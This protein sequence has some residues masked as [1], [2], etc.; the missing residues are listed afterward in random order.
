[1]ETE[2]RI[3]ISKNYKSV[4][5]EELF[6]AMKRSKNHKDLKREIVNLKR[7]FLDKEMIVNVEKPYEA[8]YESQRQFLEKNKI[9]HETKIED[10]EDLFSQDHKKLMKENMNLIRIINDLERE[11]KEIEEKS[12]DDFINP[13]KTVVKNRQHF[14]ESLPHFT[15]RSGSNEHLELELK[16]EIELLEQKIQV[17]KMEIKENAIKQKKNQNNSALNN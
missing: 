12:I 7:L 13:K 2:K 14:K 3:E 8:N 6:N 10:S 5:Q 17:R 9:D 15:K 1:M 16:K 4:F 11:N